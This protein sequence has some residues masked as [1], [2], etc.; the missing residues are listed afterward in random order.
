MSDSRAKDV[1]DAVTLIRQA[2]EKIA[3]L[4]RT[5]QE[6]VT[7]DGIIVVLDGAIERIEALRDE[8]GD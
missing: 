8:E 7:T 4:T 2:M 1:D 5:A 3:N 6:R